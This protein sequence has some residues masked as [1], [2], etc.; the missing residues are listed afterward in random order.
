MDSQEHTYAFGRRLFLAGSGAL[1]LMGARSAAAQESGNKPPA[2]LDKDL[3]QMLA[4]FV[5]AFDLKQVPAEVVELA[6]LGFID[7]VGVA[8][9]G[10]HEDV[11]HI[12]AEMVKAGRLCAAM[13][14]HRQLRAC[15]AAARSARQWRLKPCDGL[16]LQLRQRTVCGAGDPRA[17]RGRGKHECHAGRIHGRLT[18]SAAR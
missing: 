16:R 17:A 9:A 12:A 1:A 6:R 8:V 11:A 5:V 3:R 15:I 13:H 10:S 7:T 14:D 18:S 4:E 2:K